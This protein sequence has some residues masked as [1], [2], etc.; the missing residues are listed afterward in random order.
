MHDQVN[1]VVHVHDAAAT[2]GHFFA[3]IGYTAGDSVFKTDNNE[4]YQ[5]DET[6]IRYMLNGQEVDTI[7]NRT[8]LIEDAL[9]ISIGSTTDDQLQAHYDQITKD[10]AVYNGQ[11]DP[12][13]CTGGKPLA[14]WERVRLSLWFDK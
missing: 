5:R 11:N 2:W 3:N 1:H 8:V 10:A 7:A 4:V 12:S 14:F 6:P 9:L 13:N